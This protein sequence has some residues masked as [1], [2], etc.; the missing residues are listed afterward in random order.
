MIEDPSENEA[1][2][3]LMEFQMPGSWN[4]EEGSSSDEE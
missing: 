4:E 3:C 2:E 1:E